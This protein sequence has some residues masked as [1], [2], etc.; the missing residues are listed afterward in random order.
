MITASV[1]S[2]RHEGYASYDRLEE[3]CARWEPQYSEIKSWGDAP[4]ELCAD[5]LRGLQADL[6][7][8]FEAGSVHRAVAQMA[9]DLPA[10]ALSGEGISLHLR[11][12]GMAGGSFRLFRL[13]DQVTDAELPPLNAGDG[14]GVSGYFLSSE[15]AHLAGLL[16]NAESQ[17]RS[18]APE[19]DSDMAA[20]IALLLATAALE[21]WHL[22]AIAGCDWRVRF[23]SELH[24]V[25][26]TSVVGICP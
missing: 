8:A 9:E 18:K 14:N 11:N 7:G 1:T 10:P 6:R 15:P 2:P 5:M 4:D 21:S 26:A 3:A 16:R 25:A 22:C 13:D 12:P 17:I 19:L 23:E 20:S 24:G